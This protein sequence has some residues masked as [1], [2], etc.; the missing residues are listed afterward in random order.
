SIRSAPCGPNSRR[1]RPIPQ[2]E[3][4][5]GLTEFAQYRTRVALLLPFSWI[6]GER[7]SLRWFTVAPGLKARLPDLGIV[8]VGRLHGD[9]LRHADAIRRGVRLDPVGEQSVPDE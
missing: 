8:L 2:S 9:V 3:S 6:A 5:Q 4:Q 7:E 1:L